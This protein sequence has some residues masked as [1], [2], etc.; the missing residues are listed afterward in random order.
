VTQP[1][2]ASAASTQSA[3]C[4]ETWAAIDAVRGRP[5]NA[6]RRIIA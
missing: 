1:A 2:L 5:I 4:A 3:R 6:D